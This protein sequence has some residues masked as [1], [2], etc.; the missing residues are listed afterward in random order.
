MKKGSIFGIIGIILFL[1]VVFLIFGMSIYSFLTIGLTGQS[2]KMNI[3]ATVVASKYSSDCD[4]VLLNL[5][6]YE[7]FTGNTDLSNAQILALS[8]HTGQSIE[9]AKEFENIIKNLLTYTSGPTTLKCFQIV[10]QSEYAK[11]AFLTHPSDVVC[12]K[13]GIEEDDVRIC[14][15]YIP[16]ISP[17]KG[18][19]KIQV[20][21]ELQTP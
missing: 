20:A 1:I 18:W 3:D 5:L 10:A 9:V 6:R 15:A 8:K 2:P 7:D 21:Y 17:D 19:I 11:E 12:L 4:I 16:D 13:E 14:E